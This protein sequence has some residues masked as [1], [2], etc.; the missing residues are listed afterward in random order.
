MDFPISGCLLFG[1]SFGGLFRHYLDCVW[2]VAAGP[3]WEHGPP[4]TLSAGPQSDV[5]S[6]SLWARCARSKSVP[7]FR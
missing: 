7:R 4:L 1:P 3:N 6:L 5:H 2:W